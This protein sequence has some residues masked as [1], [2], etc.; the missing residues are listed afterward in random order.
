MLSAP[1]SSL[2]GQDRDGQDRLVL[3]LG[4]V[5][6]GLEAG[7]EMGLRRAHDRRPFRPAAPVIPSPGFIRG[8]RVISSTRVRASLVEQAL[9]ALVER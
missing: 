7:V 2:A 9:R 3:V 4:E 8:R 5:R 1:A 6:K